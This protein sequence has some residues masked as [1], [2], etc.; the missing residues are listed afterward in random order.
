MVVELLVVVVIGSDRVGWSGFEIMAPSS[1]CAVGAKVG[2][3]GKV[4]PGDNLMARLKVID[5][6]SNEVWNMIGAT[7]CIL[8]PQWR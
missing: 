3:V 4:W 1:E 5:R 6:Q 7:F 2:G 8:V